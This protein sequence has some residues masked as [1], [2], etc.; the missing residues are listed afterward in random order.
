MRAAHRARSSVNN[1]ILS[2]PLHPVIDWLKMGNLKR[3]HRL[4][5][6]LQS[7]IDSAG[8]SFVAE[9]R[10]SLPQLTEDLRPVEPLTFTVLAETHAGYPF[11]RRLIAPARRNRMTDPRADRH[12]QPKGRSMRWLGKEA[13]IEK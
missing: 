8:L 7:L 4:N 5:S 2:C 13:P 9:S 1:L 6:Q 3:A 11:R 12:P 10:A